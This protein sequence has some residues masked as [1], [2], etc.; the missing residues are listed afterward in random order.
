MPEK[1]GKTDSQ[2][3][4]GTPL[5]CPQAHWWELAAMETGEAA[6]LGSDFFRPKR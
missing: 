4:K 6:M 1:H 3:G 2:A 5:L